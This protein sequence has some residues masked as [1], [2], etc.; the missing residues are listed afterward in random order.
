[1]LLEIRKYFQKI[2]DKVKEFGRKS[3]CA[4]SMFMTT[5]WNREAIN[6]ITQAKYFHLTSHFGSLQYA[7]REYFWSGK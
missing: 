6:S 4:K 7:Q 3:N 2:Q 1:M 5:H